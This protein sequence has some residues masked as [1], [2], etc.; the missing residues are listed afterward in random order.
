MKIRNTYLG[1]TLN[2]NFVHSLLTMKKIQ[3]HKKKSS[4]RGNIT[5]LRLI[6]KSKESTIFLQCA[7]IYPQL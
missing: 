1:K 6:K 3:D 4:N 7:R 2:L 5:K